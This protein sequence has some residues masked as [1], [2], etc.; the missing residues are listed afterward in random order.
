M[1]SF[2][3]YVINIRSDA[4]TQA[5]LFDAQFAPSPLPADI[6]IGKHKGSSTSIAA[7]PSPESKA[8]VRELVLADIAK[9]GTATVKETARRL[10]YGER[11]NII[12]GRVSELS[13]VLKLIEATGETR[14]K[15]G[16]WRVKR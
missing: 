2:A 6:T 7:N 11:I 4:M 8:R 5:T 10:G 12:S 14:E 16:V 9:H 15:S 3:I 1:R 13:L